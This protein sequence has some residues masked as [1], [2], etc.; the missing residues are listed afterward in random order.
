MR[1]FLSILSFLLLFSAC[2]SKS[3]DFNK[4]IDEI[5]PL[6]DGNEWTY[7]VIF[8]EDTS[9]ATATFELSQMSDDSR[10]AVI[11]LDLTHYY[12]AD[13][14]GGFMIE[15]VDNGICINPADFDFV[16][17]NLNRLKTYP[18]AAVLKYPAADGDTYSFNYSV[19]DNNYTY[20]VEVSEEILTVGDRTYTAL[21][22][23]I[24]DGKDP[25][26]Y[27]TEIYFN[28]DIGIIEMI[29]PSAPENKIT[30]LSTNF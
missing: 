23:I 12:F 9:S 17:E 13:I 5:Y 19:L 10:R 1:I 28:E 29:L 26:L 16:M 24:P 27:A 20:N 4:K 3:N 30:L 21:K 2:S 7:Q 18:C 8:Y 14:L 6:Q 11:R 25:D 22:Y 15:A